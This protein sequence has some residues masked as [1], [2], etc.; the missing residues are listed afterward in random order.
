MQIFD[1][2]TKT[3][4]PIIFSKRI[5]GGCPSHVIFCPRF[6]IGFV[7]ICPLH[8]FNVLEMYLCSSC[9]VMSLPLSLY[10]ILLMP[11]LWPLSQVR[12]SVGIWKGLQKGYNLWSSPIPSFNFW[13]D[14]NLQV[15][16]LF[17]IKPSVIFARAQKKNIGLSILG[18]LYFLSSCNF[19]WWIQLRI[20]DVT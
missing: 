6:V 10:T 18:L 14:R 20:G 8:S 3:I 19:A 15:C 12:L 7:Y 11:L 16:H 4:F 17:F 1:F 2:G 13:D 5:K 9:S